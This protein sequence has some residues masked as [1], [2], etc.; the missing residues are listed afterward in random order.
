MVTELTDEQA[1]AKYLKGEEDPDLTE[2]GEMTAEERAVVEAFIPED[3][4]E[5][6]GL[7]SD[8]PMTGVD[9]PNVP[10]NDVDDQPL[11]EDEDED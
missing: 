6:T 4:E 9:L 11:I 8:E 5:D 10:V 1:E 3:D 2:G 7:P